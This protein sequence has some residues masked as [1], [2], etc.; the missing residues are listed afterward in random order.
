MSGIR[1]K[2]TKPELIVR[3]LLHRMG[4]RFRLHHK[5]LPGKPD[6][7]RDRRNYSLLSSLG[8]KVVIIWECALS[9]KH[10][11]STPVLEEVISSALSSK[12]THIDIRC[13]W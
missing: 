13:P 9:K 12:E 10:R 2:D 11:L 3:R 8:W 7:A 4:H 6:I 5:D 1:E